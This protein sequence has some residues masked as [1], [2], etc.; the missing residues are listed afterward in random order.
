MIFSCVIPAKDENDPSLKN[1]IRKIRMQDFPQD[2]IETIVVTEGNSEEAKGKGISLAKGEIVGM[3]CCDNDITSPYL[4][5]TVYQMI[6]GNPYLTG[7]Y[8]KHYAHRIDD[9]SLNRYFSL[10][11]CNDP[12]MLYLNKADRKSYIEYS[13]SEVFT[14][15]RFINDIP[16]LGDNGFFFNREHLLL[17]DI[18]HFYPMDVCED[19]RKKG[20]WYYGR[21][22]NQFLWHRTTDNNLFAFLK[23]RF[24][25]AESLFCDKIEERRW[26][27]V[28]KKDIPK[29]ALF[30]LHSLMPIQP[31]SFSIVGFIHK[32]DFAWFWHP[33]VMLG[34]SIMYGVLTLKW[35]TKYLLSFLRLGEKKA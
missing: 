29:L 5:S 30:V 31:L 23:R 3:F 17:S 35:L 6:S 15:E 13:S 8:T 24:F 20:L 25:Y 10:I 7:V 28:S 2:E 18:D 21:M 16:S 4:F 1:L 27:A 22:N 33:I 14:I 26:K 34:F 32:R 11:G 19:M 9:N 12:V